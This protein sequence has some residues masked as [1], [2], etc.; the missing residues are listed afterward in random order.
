MMDG[1]C[2]G[3]VSH[4]SVLELIA[5]LARLEGTVRA[6][7]A[8]PPRPDGAVHHSADPLIR[9]ERLIVSELEDRREA[10][11]AAAAHRNAREQT[12]FVHS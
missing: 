3:A 10:R 2:A 7:P 8:R 12:P 4:L 11:R 1:G 6:L 9:R 5:E